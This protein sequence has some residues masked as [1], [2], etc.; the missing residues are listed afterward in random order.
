VL[1]IDTCVQTSNSV[2]ITYNNNYYFLL[3]RVSIA[4]KTGII[5]GNIKNLF[6]KGLNV[7]NVTKKM[8]KTICEYKST[9]THMVH[10]IVVTLI[11]HVIF[12]I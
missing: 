2:N 6:F 9:F 4:I 8:S 3:K 12:G 11:Y 10:N 5:I 7:W 1:V